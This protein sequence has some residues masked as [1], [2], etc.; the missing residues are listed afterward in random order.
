MKACC[1]PYA[2]R[3]REAAVL[4]NARA[5]VPRLRCAGVAY[6]GAL[7]AGNAAWL[8]VLLQPLHDRLEGL[9]VHVAPV[10]PGEEAAALPQRAASGP[11]PGRCGQA[12]LQRYSDVGQMHM[13][14]LV[15]FL[16]FF[17][18]AGSPDAPDPHGASACSLEADFILFWASAKPLLQ[19]ATSSRIGQRR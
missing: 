9:R 10:G 12:L 3:L 8:G 17:R 15:C 7:L 4:L 6:H 14:L 11:W 18:F 16:G 1:R 2:G 19:N 5:C 13:L